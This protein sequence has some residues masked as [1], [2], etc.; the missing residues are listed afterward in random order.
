MAKKPGK[1]AYHKQVSRI[2]EGRRKYYAKWQGSYGMFIT[3]QTMIDDVTLLQDKMETKWGAGRLRL[4]IDG[5]LREKFDRQRYLYNQAVFHGD[6]ED[7]RQQSGRMTKAWHALDRAATDAGQILA[8]PEVWDIVSPAGFVYAFV[9]NQDDAKVYRKEGRPVVLM[10]LEEVVAIL[11]AQS[12]LVSA[13]LAFPDAEVVE[14]VERAV[15]DLTVDIMDTFRML[16]DPMD[17]DIGF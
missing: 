1:P 15:G 2:P 14:C 5:P 12:L 3:G 6:M 4:I 8:L 13:K 11:D 7:L 9:R 17:D 16:D 10:S